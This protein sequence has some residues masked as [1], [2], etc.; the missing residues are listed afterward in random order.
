M[1]FVDKEMRK[2][3]ILSQ[4]LPGRP[5]SFNKWVHRE[6]A[7]NKWLMLGHKVRDQCVDCELETSLHNSPN[8]GLWLFPDG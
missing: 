4:I 2:Q 6:D 7:H 8:C 5:E 3:L 1:T